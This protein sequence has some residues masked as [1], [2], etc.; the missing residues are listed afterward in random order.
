MQDAVTRLVTTTPQLTD[1]LDQASLEV[2]EGLLDQLVSPLSEEE[3]WA[4]LSV[5]PAN[6]DTAFGLN[7]TILHS[8]EAAPSWPIWA[9]LNDQ[10]HGWVAILLIRLNNAGMAAPTG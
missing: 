4:L 7:W 9:A 5:L 10:S 8:I 6:G 1:S 3:V 2:A